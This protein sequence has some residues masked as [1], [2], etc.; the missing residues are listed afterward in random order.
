MGSMLLITNGDSA[1]NVIRQAGIAGEYLPWRDFLHEGPVPAVLSLEELSRIR[2]Q[3]I[4]QDVPMEKEEIIDSFRFRDNTLKNFRQYPS[5]VLLFEHDLYDQLQLLQLLHWFS[6]QDRKGIPLQIVCRNEF[7]GCMTPS[8]LTQLFD[9]R[10][11]ITDDHLKQGYEAWEA[12]R[13]PDPRDW[14]KWSEEATPA[15]PFLQESA[16]RHMQ[17]YPSLKNGLNRTESSILRAV[18]DGVEQPMEIFQKVQ[19]QEESPFMGD[20]I[21]W[22]YLRQLSSPPC[23]L[24]QRLDGNEFQQPEKYPDM[25]SF[26]Q[27]RFMLT[28]N[29]K[30]VLLDKQDWIQLR[31]IDKW[32]GGVHLQ[33]ENIWRWDGIGR[34]LVPGS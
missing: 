13:S 30:E 23:P 10:E 4:S 22:G 11:T 25:K 8:R 29:G 33:K 24:L 21:L 16:L 15:L 3:F 34:E 26:N 9:E 27:Q 32:L 18:Q 17:Q 6:Q 12:F 19:E 14:Q 31:G 28:P 2:A 1:V 7:I 20:S 5:V